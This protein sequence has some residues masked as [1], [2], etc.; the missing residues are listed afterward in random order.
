MVSTH[1]I[2]VIEIFKGSLLHLHSL[3]V[4]V[5]DGDDEIEEVA[6]SHVVRRLFL[7]LGR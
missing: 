6:L 3:L 4:V 5:K 1:H 7:K 2:C